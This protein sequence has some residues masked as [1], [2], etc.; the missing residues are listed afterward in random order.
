MK[1]LAGIPDRQTIL[2]IDDQEANLITVGAVLK[3]SGYEVLVASN[4]EQASQ[5]LDSHVPDLILLD[6]LMPG[7]N[8]IEICR[9]V[10]ADPR[11]EELPVIFLSAADD[12]TLIVEALESGGVDY[13]TKP[14][15]KAE[16]LTR[17]RT[18]LSLQHAK[19]ELRRL[20]E[21]KDELLG[22]LT[23][24]LQNHLSGMLLSAELLHGR[25]SEIPERNAGLIKNIVESSSTVLDF[26]QEFLANQSAERQK[27]DFS[28]LDLQEMLEDAVAKHSIMAARK[29][30]SLRA[31]KCDAHVIAVGDHRRLTQV[32]DN[33]VTNAVKFSPPARSIILGS[34]VEDPLWAVLS[35][36]DEG[37]GFTKQDMEKIFHRYCRLS[38]RPT[39][40]EPSTGLGLS[41]VKRLVD[42]MNGS[43]T[44]ESEAGHGA[45]FT[46]RLP[47]VKD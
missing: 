2:V 32:I 19:D 40:G 8:G 1:S 3:A 38:A 13:V 44:L 5:L 23:H 22:I 46:V 34:G 37:P 4:A 6:V 28:V 45:C 43:I 20:A 39:G 33:L 9:R 16:L 15:N 30:I 10:K 12:K 26:V 25:L 24:D 47:L 31:E 11:W 18:H 21:D 42:G 36:K 41:I 27:L 17:V 14:F 35:V 7:T 29:R